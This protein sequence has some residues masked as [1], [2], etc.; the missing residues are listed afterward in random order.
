MDA[1]GAAFEDAKSVPRP[2]GATSGDLP[3]AERWTAAKAS[4]LYAFPGK[5]K[6][7]PVATLPELKAIC[8]ELPFDYVVRTKPLEGATH[9]VSFPPR[10]HIGELR[11]YQPCTVAK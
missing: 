10:G 2:P 6:A 4:A 9:V 1:C 7:S 8:R 11:V 3:G 5:A